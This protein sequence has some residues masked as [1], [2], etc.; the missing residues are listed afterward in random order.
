LLYVD[1]N[2]DNSITY[3]EKMAV[4][5]DTMKMFSED[6]KLLGYGSAS[7][8]S[9][10]SLYQGSDLGALPWKSANV[11]V[12]HEYIENG[13]VGFVFSGLTFLCFFVRWLVKR[14]FSW[15]S[16]VMMLAVFCVLGM[17]LVE[18]PFQNIAVIA[19]FWVVSMSAFRW[20]DAKVK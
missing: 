20:D 3:V 18:I 8:P 2:N 17:S 7:F 6:R 14:E 15:P 10:F 13:L 11:D 1:E 9:V 19:S 12:L 4:V 16:V 5:E